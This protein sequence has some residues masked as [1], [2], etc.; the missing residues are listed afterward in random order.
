MANI[1]KINENDL[2]NIICEA[3]NSYMVNEGMEEG[4]F[5]NLRAGFNAGKN[6]KIDQH[7]GEPK[8]AVDMVQNN[9]GQR[10]NAAKKGFGLQKN[11]TRMTNLRKELQ[12]LV[13]D[14]VINPKQTVQQLLANFGGFGQAKSNFQKQAKGMGTQLKES[15]EQAVD[16]V[17]NE[18][19]NEQEKKED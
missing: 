19:L 11:Y 6:A 13:Q 16:K 8:D 15:I 2:Q 12:Q 3:I 5:N 4:F 1:I 7:K 9:L 10:F 14:G 18:M 17:L